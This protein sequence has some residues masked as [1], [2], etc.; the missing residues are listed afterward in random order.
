MWLTDWIG[1]VVRKLFPRVDLEKKL[2]ISIAVSSDMQNAIQLWNDMYLNQPPWKGNGIRTMNLPAAISHEFARL[3]MIENQI[4]VTGSQFGNYLNTQ[5]KS[6]LKDNLKAKVE[7]Y[8]ALGGIAMKPYVSGE[9]ILVDFTQADA[10]YP[11]DYDSN[12]TITGAVFVD[13][14]RIGR[15]VYTRLECHK[16]E[17]NVLVWDDPEDGEEEGNAP[18]P[19]MG[20]T[21]TV[22]NRAFKSE[23]LTSS[24]KDEYDL[25]CQH[26]LSEEIPLT[27][28]PDW[29]DL[30]PSVTIKDVEKPLFVYIRVPSANNVDK[31]SPLGA[32]VYSKAI[33]NIQD[34]DE[35]YSE[36]KFE[37]DALQAAIDA[38]VSL[39]KLDREGN[40]VLPRGME[41]VY[42]HYDVESSMAGQSTK[43]FFEVT[44]PN[45]R[46]ASLFNGLD[47]Y[48]KIVEFLCELSF[49]TISDPNSVEKTATEVEAS[50]Q[51]SYS[52]V[53]SMQE[54]W[55]TGLKDLVYSMSVLAQLY[56]LAQV[57]EYDVNIMW[58]D[59]I[60]E[61]YDKEYQRR[62]SMVVAGKYKLE[63]FLAWHFGVSVE[64]ALKMI[65]EA[66]PGPEFPEEE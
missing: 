21:Y 5:L 63:L 44:A 41:R 52:A 40:P 54:A 33:E 38:D 13:A 49:G 48:L 18:D 55:D 26:P 32:S 64:E 45:F 24:T 10:F 22:T 43:P 56:D 53:C 65:P 15:Y 31:R 58:G 50:K 23:Q 12:G 8:C 47:H 61:D 16:F 14:K 39:F 62:W 30:E 19:R 20:N 46:D 9:S 27:E 3:I 66:E 36:S 25:T 7:V 51:R 4:E 34:A 60:L 29:A 2:G 37:F 17:R 57:G 6:A 1:K 35:Q 59:G 28:V 11:T 42:R